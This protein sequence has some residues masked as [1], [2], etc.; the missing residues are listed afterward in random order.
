MPE[1]TDEK[2]EAHKAGYKTISQI[3]IERV[4]R[5][6]AKINKV[7][8]DTGF[9]VFELASS[10]F[11][12]N[13]FIPDAEKTPVE[14]TKLFDL[15][16]Q[17]ASQ[18]SLFGTDQSDL[19]AEI[20]LKDGFTL[21]HATTEQKEFMHNRVLR[22]DDGAKSA[23]ICIDNSLD[24]VTIEQ[25]RQHTDTRFICLEA[26]LDTSKKWTL[27]QILGSNLWVA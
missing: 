14:N 1:T 22:L 26:A 25:L 10:N 7:G 17:Q 11:P 8:V 13:N 16:V 27:K 3:C 9:K 20:A 15:Y 4:K 24:P 6:G 2:S 5:A 23:L 18:A 21:N 12:E 19:L